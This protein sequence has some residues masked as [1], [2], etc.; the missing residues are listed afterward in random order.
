MI[1]YSRCPPN[2]GPH[3]FTMSIID[4]ESDVPAIHQPEFPVDHSRREWVRYERRQEQRAKPYSD[5]FGWHLRLL[6]VRAKRQPDVK[7]EIDELFRLESAAA[8]LEFSENE[9]AAIIER[10]KDEREDDGTN[11][12]AGR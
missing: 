11:E 10:L 1:D 5:E 9:L 8:G 7:S 6:L 2:M 3:E 12:E 4:K